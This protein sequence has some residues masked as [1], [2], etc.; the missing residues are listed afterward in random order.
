MHAGVVSDVS[1]RGLYV[2]S[3]YVPEAG[4]KIEL[5]LRWDGMDEVPIQ[6]R[7]ARLR[8]SHRAAVAVVQGGFSVEI[9]SAPEGFFQLLVGL[10]LG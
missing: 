5:I 10:G 7:V 2:Q 8:K 9:D 4:A 6:G 1:A 3:S